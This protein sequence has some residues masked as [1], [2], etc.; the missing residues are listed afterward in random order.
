MFQTEN[1]EHYRKRRPTED[2]DNFCDAFPM[3]EKAALRT[4]LSTFYSRP[5]FSQNNLLSG[6]GCLKTLNFLISYGLDT[7][8]F[9]EITKALK[10]L[11][12]LPMTTSETERCFSTL[13][14]IKSFLRNSMGEDRLAALGMLSIEKDMVKEIPDFNGKVIDKF[15]SD[16]HRRMEFHYK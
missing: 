10:I 12:T 13:K 3:V 7:T 11:V 5:E 14:L 2:I 9:K 8:A 6:S 4:E 16:K 15:A 1:Y